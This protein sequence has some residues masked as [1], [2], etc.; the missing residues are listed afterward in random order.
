MTQDWDK[1][2]PKSDAVDHRKVT[3]KNRVGIDI[4]ADMYSPKTASADA[5]L[6][7]LIVGHPYGGVKEQTAGFY[8]QTMAGRGFITLAFDAS[9]GGE[10]GGEPRRISSPEI[11]AEDF[12][13][14]VDYLGVQ[15]EV[16]RNRIGVIGVCGSGGFSLVAAQVDPRIKALATISMYD[17][18]GMVREGFGKS[19]TEE[20]YRA[21]LEAVGQQRWAE[22]AGA[23][24]MMA[25]G[26]PTEITVDMPRIFREFHDYYH[27]PRGQHRRTPTSFS[28]TS[29]AIMSSARPFDNLDLIAPRPLL[30]VAGSEAESRYFS[31]DAY[32]MASEP[33]ELHIVPSATHV[34]LY[35]KTDLIPW[36][37]LT[38]FFDKHLAA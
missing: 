20:E 29:N 1:T 6:A 24:V 16:D 13:A 25:G 31:E 4:V 38:S 28:M 35:D 34:D 7:A 18:G 8:A 14:A 33:K 17:I 5:P 32:E 9:F 26:A 36:D 27:T 30:F 2:F 22:A 10:S 23:K 21:M 11:F 37:K 3:Y 12:I 15:P 19:Q